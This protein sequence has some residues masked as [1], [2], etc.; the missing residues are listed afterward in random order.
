MG[1]GG[2]P[3]AAPSALT[4]ALAGAW[5]PGFG[6]QQPHGAVVLRAEVRAV[7]WAEHRAGG[8]QLDLRREINGGKEDGIY[9]KG[10]DQ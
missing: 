10:P 2:A 4:V 1:Q 6:V 9:I 5:A 3:A 8:G 7:R